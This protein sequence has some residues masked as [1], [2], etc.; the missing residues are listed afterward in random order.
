MQ[1]VLLKYEDGYHYQ[2]IMAPLVKLEADYDK[3]SKDSQGQDGLSVR[4]DQG[5]NKKHIALFRLAQSE[6]HMARMTAGD[7]LKLS[8][9]P[10]GQR[11]HGKP[12]EGLGHVLRIADSEVALMMLGGMV[13]TEITDG[14]Q[15]D[16]VWK[17]VS[18]DRMQV[19]LKTFAV[20]DTSVSGYIYHRLLGHEV[21][22]Q[23]LRVTLPPR[24]SAPGLPELNH[25]QFT[26]VKA[27]LQRPLSLIQGPPG[28]GKT[29]TSATLVYHL[30][31]QGMG[32]VL[33]CAPSNVAV[34]HLTAKISATGLRVV[35]LCA[36]SREAVSTDVDHL[37]L[38]VM[39]RALDTPDK[40]DLRKLQLL[41]DELGELVAADEKRFRRLRSSAEREILQAADVICTT[42]VGAGDPRLSNVNL[43]FRQASSICR[44]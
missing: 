5:L 6:E 17:A 4:W 35:R 18:Y 23:V 14:Y 21:E 15:V 28:T 40:Q 1:P 43:R 29:V 39:V 20:D 25:S 22:P 30:A 32:Q 42:C 7:E 12:W 16:F 38:H 27:V 9:D 8:L 36:K 31:R 24:F 44:C 11:A 10:V 26:A 34:D 13:P 2:N 33:V 41:K 3:S 19:A 37:S